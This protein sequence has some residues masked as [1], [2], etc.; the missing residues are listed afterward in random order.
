MGGNV[1]PPP[2]VSDGIGATITSSTGAVLWSVAALSDV[3]QNLE[4]P[5][6][7]ASASYAIKDFPRFYAPEW[8]PTPIPA[9]AQ[10]AVDPALLPT[11]GF[12]YRN[13]VDG[14]TYVFL[15]GSTLDS[16]F[17]ARREFVRLAGSTPAIPDWAF[18]T[19]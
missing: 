2:P 17:D 16:W 5:S 13:N 1:G 10:P 19:W 12:D 6:P 15:L 9:D 8:G 3:G 18:G 14:D 11:N 7:T 4:W